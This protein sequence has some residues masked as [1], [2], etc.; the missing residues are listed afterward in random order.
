MSKV[1]C[2]GS[3]GQQQ[4]KPMCL[5]RLLQAETVLTVFQVAHHLISQQY[6]EAHWP[7]FM[8]EK[9]EAKRAERG[10]PGPSSGEVRTS[11]PIQ[12]PD[13]DTEFPPNTSALISKPFLA[14]PG[15]HPLRSAP[16]ATPQPPVTCWLPYI[17]VSWGCCNK[18]PLPEPPRT[19]EMYVSQFRGQQSEIKMSV[20]PSSLWRP[21]GGTCS[22]PVSQLL[23]VPCLVAAELQSHGVVPM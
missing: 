22:R 19:T 9:T 2:P 8:D 1:T 21:W 20:E 18:A 10:H 12:S 5:R 23:V 3:L 17:L 16:T 13:A 15:A 11:R 7:Y 14:D 6:H 4:R